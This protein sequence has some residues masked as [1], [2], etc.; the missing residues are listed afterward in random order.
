MFGND[1]HYHH[2]SSDVRIN[3]IEKRAATD[4]SVRLLKEMEGEALS[5][6][7]LSGHLANNKLEAQWHVFRD[8][9]SHF[10]KVIIVYKL[11][12]QEYTVSTE[13]SHHMSEDQR[14]EH[15]RNILAQ[16]LVTNILTECV[17]NAPKGIESLQVLR[18]KVF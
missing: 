17:E 5:K 6:L 7:V 12:G 18:G 13:V 15:I 4:E 16:H 14:F 2:A 3:V 1:Y 9:L 10:Y 11:N 8:C